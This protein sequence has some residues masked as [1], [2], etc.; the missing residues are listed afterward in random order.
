MVQLRDHFDLPAEPVAAEGPRRVGVQQLERDGAVVLP[1]RCEINGRGAPSTELPLEDV[2]P[3]RFA[4][5][6][7]C[8]VGHTTL[9]SLGNSRLIPIS[10]ARFAMSTICV[11]H[12]REARASA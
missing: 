8:P 9:V 12:L 5:A 10:D 11:N 7:R 4:F 1:I 2:G 6:R 3:D